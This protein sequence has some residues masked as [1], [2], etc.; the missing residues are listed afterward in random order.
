[1]R[2][3]SCVDFRMSRFLYLSLVRQ[4]LPVKHVCS[5]MAADRRNLSDRVPWDDLLAS[6]KRLRLLN[7]EAAEAVAAQQAA[8]VQR[9]LRRLSAFEVH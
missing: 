9:R 5:K 3:I 6:R 7:S 1:M 4:S 2:M 8:V